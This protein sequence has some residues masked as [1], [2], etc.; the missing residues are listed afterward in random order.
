ME[1][2]LDEQVI[3]VALLSFG[4][5][6]YASVFMYSTVIFKSL[7]GSDKILQWVERLSDV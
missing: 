5:G 2:L 6:H 4:H 3:E 1:S 7:N